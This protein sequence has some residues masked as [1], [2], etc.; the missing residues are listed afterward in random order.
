MSADDI[1]AVH[2]LAARYAD[3]MNHGDAPAAVRTFTSDGR[4]ETS[5]SQPAVGS[6][7]ITV[8]I[9]EK[10]AALELIFQTVHV[11]VVVVAGQT[12]RARFPITEW[13]RRA[14]DSQPFVLLGWYEDELVRLD[15][16]WRFSRRRLVPRTVAKSGFMNAPLLPTSQLMFDL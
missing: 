5:T 6:A 13:S 9:A 1:Q 11:G 2:Q 7:A 15:D 4:L 12:A 16:G 10:M 8:V 3:A 14:D